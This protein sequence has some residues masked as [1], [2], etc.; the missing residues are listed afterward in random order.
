MW[1]SSLLLA[2]SALT[3]V[4][5]A[6]PLSVSKSQVHT[7]FWSIERDFIDTEIHEDIKSTM[8]ML[9]DK[10]C[11]NVFAVPFSAS[12]PAD[13]RIWFY[14]K[15]G[16]DDVALEK[17]SHGLKVIVD[18]NCIESKADAEN[19]VVFA[20]DVIRRAKQLEDGEVYLY[21]MNLFQF[22]FEH[23]K[24][25]N[26]L[27][28]SGICPKKNCNDGYVNPRACSLCICPY[29]KQGKNCARNATPRGC[30]PDAELLVSKNTK[31]VL[32]SYGKGICTTTLTAAPGY[33]ID[34]LVNL[35]NFLG[36]DCTGSA[37]NC[38]EARGYV[39]LEY[40]DRSHNWKAQNRYCYETGK[41][42][43]V[44]YGSNLD[45]TK[46]PAVRITYLASKIDMS[47]YAEFKAVRSNGVTPNRSHEDADLLPKDTFLRG[48]PRDE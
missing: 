27:Y 10:S 11:L 32:L 23:M 48:V 41:G 33:Y 39:Q 20:M 17:D 36:P 19:Y 3:I 34:G 40:L 46:Y 21:T 8:D 38:T 14:E 25:I 1:S 31:E 2:T 47:F 45:Y 42:H 44:P 26:E 28:C 29:H 12:H 35:K 6:S 18:P 22:T 5:R 37:C 7:L 16:C 9:Q 13:I 30:Q 43:L 24:L 15:Y 4:V